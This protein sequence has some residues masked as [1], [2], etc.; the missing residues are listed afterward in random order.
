M[1]MNKF[2]SQNLILFLIS[3]ATSTFAAKVTI[4]VGAGG[5]KYSP[6]NMTISVGDTVVSFLFFTFFLFLFL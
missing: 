2:A 1:I 6:A 4:F 3:I 5:L